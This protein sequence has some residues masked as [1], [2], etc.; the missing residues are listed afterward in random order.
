[1]LLNELD[2]IRFELRQ[3]LENLSGNGN[4][5]LSGGEDFEDIAEELEEE[6]E[7]ILEEGEHI[8]DEVEHDMEEFGDN[9]EDDFGDEEGTEIDI[10]GGPNGEV[11]GQTSGSGSTRGRR[12]A[13][14]SDSA[15]GHVSASE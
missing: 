13:G 2:N 3:E 1:M 6:G 10:T 8:L 14:I 9:M 4:C 11:S 5:G 7:H 12:N 15:T